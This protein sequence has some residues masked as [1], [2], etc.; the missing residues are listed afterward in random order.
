MFHIQLN[1]HTFSRTDGVGDFTIV[2]PSILPL[3]GFYDEGSVVP[4]Q[5]HSIMELQTF[6]IEHP[7]GGESIGVA[8][9]D[10]GVILHD[11]GVPGYEG[12]QSHRLCEET[13]NMNN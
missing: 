2:S 11:C 8:G 13:E 10:H 6:I 12:G 1:G 7:M 5:P 9:H 4:G 3:D